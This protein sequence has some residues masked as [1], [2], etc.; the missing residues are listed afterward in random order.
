VIFTQGEASVINKTFAVVLFCVVYFISNTVEA[1]AAAPPQLYGKTVTVSWTDDM[2]RRA[3]GE[4]TFTLQHHPRTATVYVSNSGRPFIRIHT[5]TRGQGGE[6]SEQV[7]LSGA[8]SVG[9]SQTAEFRGTSL[10]VTSVYQG[11]AQRVQIDFDG[12]YQSC[13]ASV[14]AGKQTGS[15]NAYLKLNGKKQ[16]VE[17]QSDSTS[18][19]TCAIESG[20]AFAR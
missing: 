12:N 17:V 19:A 9:G 18:S 13:T 4:E 3:E 5:I 15:S 7:G 20:N 8:T 10:T 16:R 6:V 1:A 11:G 14:I 2:V